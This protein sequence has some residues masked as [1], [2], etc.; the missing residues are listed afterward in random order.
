MDLSGQ[1]PK[2]QNFL[3]SLGSQFPTSVFSKIA[4]RVAEKEGDADTANLIISIL[5]REPAG[6][7]QKL[8]QP[9][10]KTVQI[11]ADK[12]DKKTDLFKINAGKWFID[13]KATPADKDWASFSFFVYQKND[14][15]KFIATDSATPGKLNGTTYI[16]KGNGDFYLKVFTANLSGWE[17]K[18]LE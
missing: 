9:A 6:A 10:T 15:Y 17:I 5:G 13:W 2:F 12:Q 1:I 8:T 14:P 16:N 18:I 7:D 11:I 3:L 4:F